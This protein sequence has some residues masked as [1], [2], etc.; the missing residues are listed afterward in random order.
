MLLEKAANIGISQDVCIND[1][2]MSH[3]TRSSLSRGVMYP[4]FCLPNLHLSQSF[5]HLKSCHPWKSWSRGFK[6]QDEASIMQFSCPEGRK[7]TAAVQLLCSFVLQ[8][9][10]NLIVVLT[11][12]RYQFKILWPCSCVLSEASGNLSSKNKYC[13]IFY[14]DCNLFNFTFAVEVPFLALVYQSHHNLSMR[15]SNKILLLQV[16]SNAFWFFLF[17]LC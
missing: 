4:V 15:M 1:L 6:L 9:L 16:N 13:V 3:L 2:G 12:F 8:K 11:V 14:L 10:F 7:K 17:L 5:L